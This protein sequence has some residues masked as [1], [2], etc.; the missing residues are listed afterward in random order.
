MI[1][2]RIPAIRRQWP[3]ALVRSLVLVVVPSFLSDLANPE[4]RR[5]PPRLHPTSYLDGLRGL[6]ACA[7]FAYHY[8]DYNH[9]PFLPHYG[10]NNP[11]EM[12][13]SYLQLPYIRLLYSGTPMV[14][15]FFVISGFALS[16]RPLRTLYSSCSAAGAPDAQA[17]AKA[18]SILA[19]SAFRRPFRLF[20]PPMI[21][22]LLTA[23]IV[24]MGYMNKYM[25]P[26]ET[27]KDQ[28]Y[29]WWDDVFH[30]ITYPWAWDDGSPKSQYNPHLWT[31]P[32]EFVH[33]MFLFLVVL[34]SSRLRSTY[35][36]QAFF[37]LMM[38][39]VIWNGRW[40]AFEFLGG[41]LLADMYL[42]EQK[43]QQ[44]APDSREPEKEGLITPL[45]N[46]GASPG[47]APARVCRSL[48]MVWRGLVDAFRILVL[49][50]A[51]FILSWPPRG[52]DMTETYTWIQSLAPETI[53]GENTDR[54]KNFW[55]AVAAFSTVW[56]SGRVALFKR[57][58]N[59]AVAQYAGNISF[60]F[61]ILQHPVLNLM[62]HNVLGSQAK[63][64]QGDM[65]AQE[66][67]GVRGMTDIKTP[68]Q[69]TICWL[70][71]LVII[72][73]VLVWLADLFTR[74]VDGPAVKFARWVESLCFTPEEPQERP[75]QK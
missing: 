72:G 62:Q 53:V 9:K 25:Q 75:A 51:G 73:S 66:P 60:C 65:P 43:H 6:A 31:I 32:M 14:H 39:L 56:A 27:V 52:G 55:L 20:L 17:I 29:H 57:V 13:S 45:Q 35:V 74:M 38:A 3:V 40:A 37:A 33:S 4:R 24:R 41:A 46:G 63:P 30:R 26:Q 19:S 2:S 34:V 12:G 5:R 67:W 8:T 18:H 69:R 58:L 68:F 11:E 23:A 48:P 64:A 70:I 28:F 50:G 1:A 71:G 54:A 16:F 7:V 61:Y 10:N 44:Q 21:T 49:V 59:S 47:S 36:R 15:I 22:T 42:A